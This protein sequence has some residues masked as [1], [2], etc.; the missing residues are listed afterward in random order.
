MSSNNTESGSDFKSVTQIGAGYL[1]VSAYLG[2]LM[3]SPGADLHK[4]SGFAYFGL[5]IQLAFIS[6]LHAQR[7]ER[8]RVLGRNVG[9]WASWETKGDV[10]LVVINCL[11]GLAGGWMMIWAILGI[12]GPHLPV[13]K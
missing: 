9:K 12:V 2:G 11:F 1:A 3:F 13:K 8:Q 5:L 10:P 6:I 7:L 4:L